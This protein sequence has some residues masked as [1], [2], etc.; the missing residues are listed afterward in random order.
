[1]T[2]EEPGQNP[3]RFPEVVR[4][5]ENEAFQEAISGLSEEQVDKAFV[6]SLMANRIIEG[7]RLA[8]VLETFAK[9]HALTDLSHMIEPNYGFVRESNSQFHSINVISLHWF[10]PDSGPA[11]PSGVAS[12]AIVN[13][14]RM[15]GYIGART[16]TVVKPEEIFTSIRDTAVVLPVVPEVAVIFGS[17]TA[18]RIRDTGSAMLENR[19]ELLK[20]I[21]DLDTQVEAIGASLLDF[22]PFEVG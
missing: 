5:D 18:R 8:S 17:A 14:M 12:I 11:Y 22:S 13:G 6:N 21:G 16:G 20:S 4:Y 15:G 3:Y 2:K 7:A 1:M 19:F 9:R 10:R